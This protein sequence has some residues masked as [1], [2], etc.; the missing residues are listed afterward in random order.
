MREHPCDLTLSRGLVVVWRDW[1]VQVFE[2]VQLNS[3]ADAS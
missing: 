1:V 2:L 3:G